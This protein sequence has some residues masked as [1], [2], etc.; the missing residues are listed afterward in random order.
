[1][2]TYYTLYAIA[3]NNPKMADAHRRRARDEVVWVGNTRQKRKVC[4]AK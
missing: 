4:A 3:I 2:R 1:M